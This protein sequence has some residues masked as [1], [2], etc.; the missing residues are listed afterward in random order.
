MKQILMQQKKKDSAL[1]SKHKS[2]RKDQDKN[3]LLL[4]LLQ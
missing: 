4:M 1:N 2:L 3:V